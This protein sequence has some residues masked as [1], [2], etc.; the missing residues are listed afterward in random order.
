MFENL[1]NLKKKRK[2]KFGPAFSGANIL[3]KENK[4]GTT[5]E[6]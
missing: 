1:V 6:S 2:V 4:N 3:K 5:E